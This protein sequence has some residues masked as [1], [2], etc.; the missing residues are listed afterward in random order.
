MPVLAS[1]LAQHADE[2]PFL[3]LLRDQLTR[4]PGV[5]LYDLV[6]VDRRLRHNL[7]GLHLAGQKGLDAC[8]E[9]LET[10]EAG[11]CFTAFAVLLDHDDQSKLF[12]L[13]DLVYE[14][15]ERSRAISSALAWISFDKVKS[16][17]QKL[18]MS[19]DLN[20]S[21]LGLSGFA[22]HRKDPGQQL[23]TLAARETS[24]GLARVL[25]ASGELGR[26]DMLPILQNHISDQNDACR[27]WAAWSSA[28]LG[29]EHACNQLKYFVE[30][31]QKHTDLAIR[32]LF[33][34][35]NPIEAREYQKNLRNNNAT[36][37]SAVMA[38]GVM[39]DPTLIPWLI[40]KTQE[41]E[42]ARTAAAAISTITGLDPS[43]EKCEGQCPEGFST[44]PSE[45]P[46]DDDV[47]LDPDEH[48]PWPDTKSMHAWWMRNKS[49]YR[50][51]VRYLLGRPFSAEHF[52]NVLLQADQHQRS[53]AVL[54]HGMNN[55]GQPLF[56]IRAP[57][58]YQYHLLRNTQ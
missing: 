44:G 18:I 28:V 1:V 15:P 14:D 41:P 26:M 50:G 2:A 13:I 12:T 31:S 23:N 6:K 25:K 47:S 52:I 51:N 33:L 10:G 4:M 21:R 27:F 3:W 55:P 36:Q 7:D 56:E 5:G 46:N 19:E 49:K 8:L 45:D 53:I 35:A 43:K 30:Q 9:A 34:R 38:A 16:F 17:L 24:P 48:L 11:E 29:D 54:T 22:L 42:L 20:L 58:F 37:R 32:T 39:G 57:G 40:D